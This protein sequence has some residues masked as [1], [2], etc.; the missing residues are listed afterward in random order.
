MAELEPELK[1]ESAQ[2]AQSTPTTEPF[3][4]HE[5]NAVVDDIASNDS[6][7]LLAAEDKEIQKAFNEEPRVSIKTKINRAIISWWQNK[8]L[9]YASLSALA[10]TVVILAIVPTT[11]YFF[12]NSFGARASVN[13][14]I[15][16]ES[17]HL[18]LKNAQVSVAN[19]SGKTNNEGQIK[20]EHVKLGKTNLIIQKKAYA[21]TKRPMTV[22]LGSNPQGNIDIKPVGAQYS[23]VITDWL[24]G[25][26]IE[27]AEASSGD[28]E[29][30]SDKDG[31]LLLTVDVTTDQN[32]DITI[33]TNGYRNEKIH[34]DT[35]TNNEQKVQLVPGR[36][37]LFVSKRSGKYDLY[38]V[39]VDGKNEQV[40][41]AGTGNERNDIAIVPHPKEE[42]AAFVSTRDNVRD[43]DGYQLSTLTFVNIED[44]STKSVIQS[45]RIQVLG[46]SDSKLVFAQITAGASGSNPNRQKIITYDYKSGDKKELVSLNNLNDVMMIGNDIYYAPSSYLG[47]SQVGLQK[48]SADGANRRTLLDKEVWTIIRSSYD[49][50]DLGG[51]QQ[52]Y[53]YKIGDSGATKLSGQPASLKNRLYTTS[54]DGGNALWVDERDGK[55]VLLLSSVGANATAEDKIM[56]S[57][58]GLQVPVRWLNDSSVVYR[59]QTASEVADYVLST[60]GGSAHKI[61]D[62]TATTGA[63][64]WY[65]Y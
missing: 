30:R 7:A 53:G 50:L 13:M 60:D 12:L 45:Q 15:Y 10:A 14:I 32:L 65:Y 18:P 35:N 47:G 9:R 11:R 27:K 8:K 58:S 51:G 59:V 49:K 36:K 20:L 16:D 39:D 26:P 6:D 64:R 28:Y 1:Q 48:I 42:V 57:Q 31:K 38:R 46:W 55:G 21:L 61:R 62:V 44:N 22:G 25:K 63:N 37:H 29:S 56:H 52:W 24:S 34:L 2:G 23:F 17:T 19:A 41:I 4:D 43:S 5:L 33:K 3:D 54:S 40:I